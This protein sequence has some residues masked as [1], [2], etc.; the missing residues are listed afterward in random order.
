MGC[1][2]R[3]ARY[4]SWEV[5]EGLTARDWGVPRLWIQAGLHHTDIVMARFDF[6]YDP[7]NA[8]R[9]LAALGID[10]PTLEIIDANEA[11]IEAA[12]A[13]LHS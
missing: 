3:P 9:A 2:V 7:N 6:A 4:P 12:G 5:N 13:G 11:D 1:G 8:A 10:E